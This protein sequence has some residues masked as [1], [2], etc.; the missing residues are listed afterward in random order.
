MNAEVPRQRLV[1]SRNRFIIHGLCFGGGSTAQAIQVNSPKHVGTPTRKSSCC[2]ER[3]GGRENCWDQGGRKV[4]LF[5]EKAGRCCIRWKCLSCGT[6][7]TNMTNDV[8]YIAYQLFC[9]NVF[10]S[11]STVFHWAQNSCPL[12]MSISSQ[13]REKSVHKW[14]LNL[15]ALGFHK[16][17]DQETI[18]YTGAVP[19]CHNHVCINWRS[20]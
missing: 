16:M 20:C 15:V 7:F 11:K 8:P 3:M 9:M 4:L 10:E 14:A 12:H 18:E 6:L 17:C 19:E 5:L 2:G 13:F 1:A